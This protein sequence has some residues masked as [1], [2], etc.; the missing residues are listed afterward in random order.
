[1]TAQMTTRKCLWVWLA[2]M[3]LLLATW[4]TSNFNLHAYNFVISMTISVA[5]TIL[6]VLFFMHL[7]YSP[8]LLWLFAGAGLVWLII[9]IELSLSD[10]LTRG[11]TWSQ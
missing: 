8:R 9:L 10:Y 7:K 11:Y 6:I 2:L 4:V 3:L 1:M 5:K